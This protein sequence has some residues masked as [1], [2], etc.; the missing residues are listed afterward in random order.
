MFR[1][2]THS[3]NATERDPIVFVTRDDNNVQTW[4]L[5]LKLQTYDI[6]NIS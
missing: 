2:K 1:M 6:V 4:K 3:S 5:P